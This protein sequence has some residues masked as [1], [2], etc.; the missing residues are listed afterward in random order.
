MKAY[1]GTH[2]QYS[3]VHKIQTQSGQMPLTG[4]V[5]GFWSTTK[6]TVQVAHDNMS[7]LTYQSS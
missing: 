5:D 4:L 1:S 6:E 3:L 7:F 2:F